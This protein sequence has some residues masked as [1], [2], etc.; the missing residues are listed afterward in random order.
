M[1]SDYY[2]APSN[3]LLKDYLSPAS[4]GDEPTPDAYMVNNKFSGGSFVV[5]ANKKQGSVRVR[6]INSAPFSMVNVSVDGLPLQLI[7]IDDCAVDPINLSYVIVNVAQ[8]VSF[9]LNWDNTHDNLSKYSSIWLRVTGIP[10]MYP[11]D[12]PALYNRNLYGTVTGNPLDIYWKG[13]ISFDETLTIPS[14]DDSMVPIL[15]VPAPRS[16][17]ILEATP[18]T[19]Y[20]FQ[21]DVAPKATMG[22]YVLVVFQEND[23]NVNLAYINGATFPPLVYNNITSPIE[24]NVLY[25]IIFDKSYNISSNVKNSVNNDKHFFHHKESSFKL[26]EGSSTSPF[27]LPFNEVIEVFIQN[28][29]GGEHPFHVSH[30]ISYKINIIVILT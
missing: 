8:R 12:D 15:N 19:L 25:K 1:F 2:A 24:N 18:L 10:E 9:V 14:Y 3:S 23:Q 5:Y 6:F 22:M 26:I 21:Y 29:D 4:G 11:T 30:I 20:P 27:I 16:T 7:E 17:N 13:I 28:T